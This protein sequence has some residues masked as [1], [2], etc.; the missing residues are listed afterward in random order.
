MAADISILEEM[1]TQGL[2]DPEQVNVL[3]AKK[4]DLEAQD[5]IRSGVPWWKAKGGQTSWYSGNKPETSNDQFIKETGGPSY[6]QGMADERNRGLGPNKNTQASRDDFAAWQESQKP[7]S[8]DMGT[9]NNLGNMSSVH[10][11]MYDRNQRNIAANNRSNAAAAE[12]K[13]A[14]EYAATPEGKV[15]AA[16]MIMQRLGPRM[17]PQQA[18]AIA[19]AQ[20][21][22]GIDAGGALNGAVNPQFA[23]GAANNANRLGI[24]NINAGVARDG[25][26]TQ[27]E[28][29]RLMN[30][31]NIAG[32]NAQGA[33]SLRAQLLRMFGD[34]NSNEPI[35]PELLDASVA[36]RNGQSNDGFR[37]PARQLTP[38]ELQQ[39]QMG[40]IQIQSA[41]EDLARKRRE[42]ELANDP[43]SGIGRTVATTTAQRLAD[44]NDP[45]LNFKD[46]Q[47]KAAIG[48]AMHEWA[49]KRTP[50]P[51]NIQ[52]GLLALYKND[53]YDNDNSL[54]NPLNWA[55]RGS[56]APETDGQVYAD[57]LNNHF[58]IPQSTGKDWYKEYILKQPRAINPMSM[59]IPTSIMGPQQPTGNWWVQGRG[60]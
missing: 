46:P 25:F 51:A 33:N 23:L 31:G 16:K 8:R 6:E 7:V 53:D 32:I 57:Y 11:E 45:T 35:P 48:Q 4:Q 44:A 30:E 2:L 43:N 13:K 59:K 21:D 20:G 17:T 56:S 36:P 5:A 22:P 12:K 40:G 9:I 1:A 39:N 28:R 50:L 60:A 47:N 58:G 26:A 37:L 18:F 55:G 14:D 29:Q 10:K 24:A 34:R 54:L 42:N 49:T 15:N 27:T 3:R 38:Q 19:T 52:D 41:Q